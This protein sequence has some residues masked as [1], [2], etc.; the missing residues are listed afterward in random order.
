MGSSRN[1]DAREHQMD[2]LFSILPHG[3]AALFLIIATAG[4]RNEKLR[5]GRRPL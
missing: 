5:P 1:V 4:S 3:F 2:V